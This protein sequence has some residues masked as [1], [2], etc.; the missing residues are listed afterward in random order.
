MSI[1]TAANRALVLEAM[2][3]LFQRK[4]PLAVERL[5]APDYIQHNPGIAQG[6]GALAK[7]VAQLPPGVFYEPGLIIAEGAYV[8]IHGRIKGWA[9]NPQV[10]ID[11]FRVENGKLAEHWDV[12][13]DEILPKGSKS[14]VAMFSPDEASVQATT[15]ETAISEAGAAINYD[16]LMQANL[17]RVFGER[18]AE[19]RLKEIG[20]LY[21][22]DAVLNEPHT[23]VKGHAAINQAVT[24][25]LSS[26][27]PEFSFAPLGPAIGHHGIGRLRWSAGPP[28]QP[29]A[30]TGMD[31]VHFQQGRIH[32]LFVFLDPPSP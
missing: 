26:L 8:A 12:L 7:L 29:P 23:S 9:P 5:Y 11:I 25:L 30:V 22:E 4:D 6:R 19:R 27:P 2:T 17:T 1:D 24:E 16:A 20:E 13:Q 18:D 3:T 10:V 28:G 32:S 21:A 14:G 31:V 15:N